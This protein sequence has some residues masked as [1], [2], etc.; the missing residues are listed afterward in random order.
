MHLLQVMLGSTY[1]C[2][3]AV[4]MKGPCSTANTYATRQA[5]IQMNHNNNTNSGIFLVTF[6]PSCVI[7]CVWVEPMI[8]G[9]DAHMALLVYCWHSCIHMLSVRPSRP[10][11]GV[12]QVDGPCNLF[13]LFSTKILDQR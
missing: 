8:D 7:M 4:Y 5:R 11:S 13:V 6:V 9:V 10:V 2:M 1:A 12:E 3:D